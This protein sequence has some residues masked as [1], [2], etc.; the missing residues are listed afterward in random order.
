MTNWDPLQYARFGG[1]RLI[2]A[3]DLLA[4]VT[5]PP[6]DGGDL[7]ITDLGCGA[8]AATL[9]LR[10]RWPGAI[11]RGV[12]S[13]AEMLAEAR[14]GVAEGILWQRADIA[15]WSP[16]APQHL[17][18]SNAALHWL[19]DHGTLFPRLVESLEEGGV[20]A[21][22]M[23]VN[24]GA[25][26]HQILF[27]LAESKPWRGRLAGLVRRRPVAG[28]AEYRRLLE[29]HCGRVEIWITEYP[30]LLDGDDAV[31]AFTA[32]SVCRPFL[33]VLGAGERDAFLLEYRRRLRPLYE[34]RPDGRTLYPFRRLFV[35]ARK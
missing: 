35:V 23:P 14:S 5:V 28:P 18:F 24:H 16:G 11:I 27:D 22:Q 1:Q 3:R 8:G 30:Y 15:R 19:D 33:A 25:P 4:R 20:L 6:A 21:L 9:L 34:P 10:E 7:R 29:A 31:T 17:L 12:D 2:P 13:S 32:S 26:S